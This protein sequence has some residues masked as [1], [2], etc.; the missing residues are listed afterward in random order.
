MLPRKQSEFD[1][2]FPKSVIQD[3]VYNTSTVKSNK[4]KPTR[5]GNLRMSVQE[6]MENKKRI[7]MSKPMEKSI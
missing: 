7:I 6:R 2:P 5:K 1:C 4:E 3:V